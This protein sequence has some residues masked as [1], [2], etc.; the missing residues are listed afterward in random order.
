M[1]YL[2]H[3][4]TIIATVALFI[5]LG[6][7]AAA[8]ASGLINGA[9]I[10]NH[11]I[12]AK[13]LTNKALKQL[14]GNRGPAGPAEQQGIQG[15]QG[16]PGAKGDP[17][18]IGPSSALSTYNKNFV[19]FGTTDTNLASLTLPAGSYVVTANTTIA[20]G[21]NVA[22]TLCYMTDSHAGVIAQN[23]T[24]NDTTDIQSSLTIVAPL[25]SAGSTVDIDCFSSD[26][27]TFGVYTHLVAIK[28]GSVTGTLGHA[29]QKAKSQS[30]RVAN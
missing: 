5:A 1:K 29:S 3:P 20:N 17:G 6:G 15:V 13:K 4:A 16:V 2:K 19:D 14:K 26:A 12:A 21:V 10:K 24:S 25:V 22:T 23:Y 27:D 9:Q 18:P 11:S 7:G 30:S 28:L 8:Y